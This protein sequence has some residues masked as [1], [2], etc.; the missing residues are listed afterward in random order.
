MINNTSCKRLINEM[1]VFRKIIYIKF[2]HLYLIQAIFTNMLLRKLMNSIFYHHW[3]KISPLLLYNALL[4]FVQTY[5][6]M[7]FKF[8]F[9]IFF[10]K[11]IWVI[12]CWY[13]KIFS[14]SLYCF[15]LFCLFYLSSLRVSAKDLLS[16]LSLIYSVGLLIIKYIGFTLFGVTCPI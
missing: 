15:I 11:I 16:L 8:D 5:I 7:W 12:I 6:I 14:S 2:Q 13:N 3:K 4:M 9:C 10:I 1:Y